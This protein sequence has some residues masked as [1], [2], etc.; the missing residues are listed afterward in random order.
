MSQPHITLALLGL[1]ALLGSTELLVTAVT[2]GLIGVA[3]LTLVGLL[4]APLRRLL[5]GHG[6]L[7]A[8]LLL[9][10]TL[11]SV[12]GLLLQTFSSELF[13]ALALFLPLL[14]LPCLG[15]ALQRDTT[16]LAG[17]RPGLLF[18]ALAVL[19]GLLREGLGNATL[20]SHADWLFGPAA[21][22]WQ[23]SLPS[24]GGIHLLTLAPGAFILLGVLLAAA[25]HFH[26][27]D[28]P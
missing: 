19:L 5:Q 7:L 10:A 28:T 11:L 14:L 24:L 12:A 6:L 23:L 4:M 8:A 21:A 16:A 27:D 3:V 25:R 20:L 9:G 26:H 2:I 13:I 22:S 1:T 15:L 18:A 17:F